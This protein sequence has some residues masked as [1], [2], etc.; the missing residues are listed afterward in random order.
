MEYDRRSL[1][2]KAKINLILDQ[3]NEIE[4]HI[5]LIKEYIDETTAKH[6]KYNFG[7]DTFDSF[8]YHQLQIRIHNDMIKSVLG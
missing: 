4:A 1:S 2:S 6:K 7:D 8:Y 3:L 5:A